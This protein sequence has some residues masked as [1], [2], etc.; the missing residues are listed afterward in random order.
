VPGNSV[1]PSLS[2][3]RVLELLFPETGILLPN[4]LEIS[5][6]SSFFGLSA[7]AGAEGRSVIKNITNT[8]DRRLK[9]TP[10]PLLYIV[11]ILDTVYAISVK[12]IY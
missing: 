5:T 3:E 12:S 11:I 4:T 1:I 10:A 9:F 2:A 8:A 7:L 6:T